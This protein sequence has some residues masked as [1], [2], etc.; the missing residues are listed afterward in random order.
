[1]TDQLE[2]LFADLRAE[3][4][5]RITPPGVAA[6]RATVRRRRVR[7]TA[8]A[9]GL[10]AMAAVGA[11]YAVSLPS[12]PELPAQPSP[13]LSAEQRNSLALEAARSIGLHDAALQN[14][15][16]SASAGPLLAKRLLRGDY[17]LSAA[18][19]GD[20]GSVDLHVAGRT[21]TLACGREPLQ[22]S[23]T[24][25]VSGATERVV[26]DA[27]PDPAALD[28]V[29]VAWTLSMTPVSMRRLAETAEKAL[30]ENP[31][32]RRA[33]FLDS[34]SSPGDGALPSGDIRITVACAGTG[35]FRMDIGDEAAM[36]PRSTSVAAYDG[37]CDGT[38]GHFDVTVPAGT[39][40]M[41]IVMTPSTAALGQAALAY[42]VTTR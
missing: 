20:R 29:G 5:P 32:G 7:R 24:F 12:P 41:I 14:G 42:R 9:A 37:K 15:G 35:T 28:R 6:V 26:V 10:A 34:L 16:T 4:L 19:A 40:R 27:R 33:F 36:D 31:A 25:T 21:L 22:R 23:L 2:H 1:M 30:G 38:A 39:K 11:G 8:L 17:Q 13:T 3:T 18:C